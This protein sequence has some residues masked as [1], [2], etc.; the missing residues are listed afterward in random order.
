MR[1]S[2]HLPIIACLS[3]CSHLL[4]A[5]VR[6]SGY[7]GRWAVVDSLI[8]KKG[9]TQSALTEVNSI[10]DLARRDKN[11]VQVIRALL[12]RMS[13]QEMNQEDATKK[14]IL[15][16]EKETGTVQQP[17]R[18]IL[19]SILAEAYWKYFQQNR[20]KMY[21]RTK[22][23]N[24]VKDD[25]ATWD[26]SDFHRKTGELYLA[27]V[28]DERLLEQTKLDAYD[29]ILSQG[30]TRYL[31]PTLFDLL[32][33]RALEYFKND[34]QDANK[35][36]Y[37]FEL[38]DPTVFADAAV[39]IGHTFV[40][41]DSLSLHFRALQLFQRLIRFHIADPRPDALLD[42][43]IERLQFANG[44]AVADNKDSLYTSALAHLTDRYGNEPAAAEAWY[45][46]AQYYA[47]QAARYNLTQDTAN[48]Y[49]YV[50]AKAICEKVIAASSEK[51]SSEG[52]SSCRVLLKSILHK[53]LSLQMEKINVPGQP[54]R[55]LVSWRNFSQLY[56]RV[57]PMG[58]SVKEGLGNNPYD[59]GYWKKLTQLPVL[60]TFFQSLPETGDYQNHRTEIKI[61]AL[62]AG[63]YALLVSNSSDFSLT[64]AALAV[65]YFSVSDIAYVNN[66]RDYF[67]LNRESGQ[68]LP[69]AA[70]QVWG[71]SYDYHTAKYILSKAES[72]VADEHG[73]FL[74]KESTDKN[75][76]ME[77]LL[78][79]TVAGDHLFPNEES[80]IYYY[81]NGEY[82]IANKAAYEKYNQK[83][84]LFT[85]RSIYRP[86]QTVYFKGIVVTRDADT[87]KAK[88]LSSYT[89]KVVLQDA[90]D[91]RVDSLNLVTNE[92]GSYHGSFRL[93]ENLLNGEFTLLD[94]STKFSQTFSVE[95][96][97]RP[98]FFVDYD[99]LKGGYRVGDSIRVT[100]NA[101][102][103]AGNTIDG[104]AVKYRV[105]RQARFPYPWRYWRG[106]RPAVSGQEIAH[107]EVRTNAEGK[108]TVAFAAIPDRRVSKDL[109][110]V[111]EYTIT[112]DITDINGETRSGQTTVS[113]SYKA[114]QLAISL[115]GGDHLPADSLREL[116]VRTTNL[117]GEPEPAA[118]HV[119]I[120]SLQSPD[121]L[122]RNRYWE[123]PDQFVM[124]MS[125]YLAAFP[126]DEYGDELKVERWQR[127]DKVA[128]RLDSSGVIPIFKGE[129][130][131]GMRTGGKVN[132]QR[133][134]PGWYAIEATTTDKYGAEV[135]D[136]KYVELYDG[137]TGRPAFPQYNWATLP[138]SPVEPGGNA[139]IDIG[140]SAGDVFVVRKIDHTMEDRKP[141]RAVGVG[142]TAGGASVADGGNFSF[143][144]LN[145]ERKTI[146][147]PITEADRGGFGVLDVFVK[148]NRVYTNLHTV[149]VPWTNKDLT[150]TYASY[151]DK[152]L[153]GSEER[154]K[155]N[156]SGYKGDR[157]AAEVLAGMYDASLDQFKMHTW[158]KPD[159]YATYI[160]RAIW[161]GNENFSAGRSLE[162]YIADD[163]GRPFVKN[164][165][166]I[167]SDGMPSRLMV[168]GRRFNTNS[169]KMLEGRVMG[170]VRAAPMAEQ[171]SKPMARLNVTMDTKVQLRGTGS[172]ALG[173]A[174]LYVVDGVIT[175]AADAQKISADEIESVQV[176]K[177][178]AASSQYGARAAN[179][180]IVITTK[181]G[182]KKDR[183][184]EVQVR[185]NFN[186]TA[187]FFPELRTDTAGN[188]NFSFTMPEALTRWKWMTLAH[189][190]D[191]AFGEGEQTIITQKQL[192]VQPNAPRFLR[193]GDRMELSAKIVNLTD[194]ELTGQV[195]LVLTDPTTEQTAD[196]MFSNRQPNQYFTVGARQSVAVAFS[197]DIP[198]Q[199]NRPLN[200]RIVARAHDYSDGEEADLPVVS[201]RMLVTET[202][203]LNMPGNGVRHLQF[204]KLL[205]SGNSETLN[206]HA[207]TVEFTAN[208]AWYAVQ[209][210]PYLMEYPYECAEQ[211]FNRF[212][213]NALAAKIANSSPRIRAIFEKW[214][215]ADTAA[216]LSNLQ[217]NQ[218]L[219]SVLLE[220]TPWVLQAK[221]ES[222]QKKNIALLFDMVR[223][224]RE[225]ESALNKLQDLQSPSGGFVWFKGGAD[226]RYIT[227]YILTGIGHLQKLNALPPS[228]AAKI[229]AMVTAALPYL[230]KKIKEDYESIKN[231][232]NTV[233]GKGMGPIR[234]VGDLPVDYLYMRSYFSDYGI[235][236]DVFPAVN[237]F[238]K[239]VQQGWL[240]QSRY[241]QGMIALA[242]F[243]TGDVKTARDIMASLR[244]NAIRDEEKGMYWKGVEGG[245]FWYQAPVETQSPLIEAFRE[246][247]PSAPVDRDLKTWLLRQKQTRSW[248]TTKATADACY[249]LLLGGA[250]WLSE[251]RTV[252]I[253]LGDKVVSS[254]SGS[255]VSAGAA[256]GA[257]GRADT[258]MRTSGSG[259]GAR[260]DTGAEA[261]T[262]YF[263]KVFDGAFVQPSMGNIT[264]TL[265]GT[266][267]AEG[268]VGGGETRPG[269]ETRAGGA[270][271]GS[272]A[273][274]AVYWQYFDNLDQITV[275]AGVKAPLKLVKKLFIEKNTD[276]GPVLEPVS[277]NGTLHVGDK[278]KVRIE[279]QADRDME[280]VHMKDMR[281]ACME[282]VNVISQ[283][284]WQGGLGYYESTKDAST[285]FFFAWLPRGTY[286][287]E[288]EL[289]V[290]QVGNFS[291]GVTSIECMYAPEFAYHS[292]GVRVS[293]EA[294]GP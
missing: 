142:A 283:Y 64:G 36:A 203:P 293:V 126:H 133:F 211:V 155:I 223:M 5:Q 75:R 190:R 240:Q 205:Q 121:R 221:S 59:T 48:R 157:A 189:T 292:E 84:F 222:Q 148:D 289:F 231:K 215:T 193:E 109:D 156:I 102:A 54:M 151:R 194:S 147:M 186:E 23:V 37:V 188:V 177:G 273:W 145:K 26:I 6:M 204:Q 168:N 65:Q 62:A 161:I 21:D 4:T 53:E 70:I 120:Y 226:D 219:K 271:G 237:Y 247:S 288:Y 140:S 135:K 57:I 290:G 50:Q 260:A 217:K 170:V 262:G 252:E 86:G 30:N 78:E 101:R 281:A 199:Y 100:G 278:V 31:R 27:S 93:P 178:D 276:R 212:Y 167:I 92:F 24:F 80:G 89:T 286:V 261:G 83:T 136:I 114:L 110:P 169:G 173:N 243:R 218:E 63:E 153:P 265:S 25:I 228:S 255:G 58:R 277:E 46:Q 105:V 224:G 180:V 206:T 174:P 201:N 94:D 158:D 183:Q 146:G 129:F 280:Y 192:M 141:E 259:A 225:L 229:K 44:Y 68:P 269:G 14:N 124:N 82:E 139:T 282:P 8:H 81:Q 77:Q 12:Y 287:F 34:E 71:R 113:T 118:V 88:I 230:D 267:G 69:G 55:S 119:T 51:D 233:T 279:L 130:P 43:D 9:L 207:L 7:E 179:G 11:D 52:K 181:S 79:I 35:P 103:Y 270:N 268:R 1:V 160:P 176:L 98:K 195:E 19:Q 213:A 107:G 128:E 266:G 162:K 198:Y 238:R 245:Y 60:N 241:M 242:L 236:G 115:P 182:G 208:P 264:V 249:A 227:Q 197:I 122:I 144:A 123:A 74:L 143:L 152:T 29:P 90:N 132:D 66:D 184:Q 257:G 40:T 33:H 108:F 191:L 91:D 76:N 258:G 256:A 166:E 263:K 253:R 99:K 137:K 116:N 172:M 200:Y 274:G 67:V 214:K 202:L 117:S 97:K 17:A 45:L 275:P 285:N 284:K 39:F 111:F 134:L 2:Y 106:G 149:Q 38:D 250:D 131:T 232:G 22:T 246:V 73:H 163:Y 47:S 165:D 104:A 291:N 56:M 294:V 87:R 18:A 210:L 251:D 171:E 41:A 95:E 187:F 125:D 127:T 220:E 28:K 138:L 175:D 20:W 85:D 16:L 96:Y 13:L 239:E 254:A 159:L 32:G 49:G 216:L 272:P 248:P 3:L 185:R 234:R 72:Y 209:A 42:V 150:I 15:D 235:P 61:D 244:Q 112:A 164:Y 196:G 10:Y 154:W